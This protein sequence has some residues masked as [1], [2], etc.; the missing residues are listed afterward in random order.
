MTVVDQP[1]ESSAYHAVNPLRCRSSANLKISCA[2]I[3]AFH[4]VKRPY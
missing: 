3:P 4:M 1:E 2:A